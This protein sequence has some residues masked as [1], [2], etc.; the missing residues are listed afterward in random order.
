MNFAEKNPKILENMNSNFYN[1]TKAVQI[2]FKNQATKTINK[3]FTNEIMQGQLT[4]I[5]N[6]GSPREI[7]KE[8]LGRFAFSVNYEIQYYNSIFA[9]NNNYTNIYDI[10]DQIRNQIEFQ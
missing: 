9:Y 3:G 6:I 1:K 5:D 10:A 7:S 2:Q 4:A 8:K